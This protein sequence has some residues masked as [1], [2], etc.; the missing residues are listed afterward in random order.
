MCIFGALRN[1]SRS[2]VCFKL[3]SARAALAYESLCVCVCESECC[4]LFFFLFI[5]GVEI[6]L[7]THAPLSTADLFDVRIHFMLIHSPR[8]KA[9]NSVGCAAGEITGRCCVRGWPKYFFLCS[10][11]LPIFF[12]SLSRVYNVTTGHLA[13][14]RSIAVFVF[15]QP[16]ICLEARYWV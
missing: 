13:V 15:L 9:G 4:W 1:F 5:R 14:F 11:F 10:T 8:C 6:G 7:R 2:M 12:L 16:P 3:R